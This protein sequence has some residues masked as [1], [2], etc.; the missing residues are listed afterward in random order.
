M[1][2][3]PAN[4]YFKLKGRHPDFINALETLGKT[5]KVAGPLDEKTVQLLQLA[6][7]AAIRS[8]G[9]VHSHTK[10]ALD[11]GATVAEIYHALIVLTSTMGFPCVAAAISWVDDVA[12]KQEE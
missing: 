2:S 4:Q 8:E 5:T 10:R 9:A 7:S 12:P 6:A 3:I 1:A 11:A